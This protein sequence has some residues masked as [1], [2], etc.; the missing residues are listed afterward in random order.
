MRHPSSKE[1]VCKTSNFKHKDLQRL[2]RQAGAKAREKR[3]QGTPTARGWSRPPPAAKRRKW[4]WGLKANSQGMGRAA[5]LS[6]FHWLG[7]GGRTQ[8]GSGG[9]SWGSGGHK[10][11]RPASPHRSLAPEARSHRTHVA[12][13]LPSATN[14]PANRS[15]LRTAPAR[16]THTR[17]G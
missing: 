1:T 17:W 14:H 6:A 3:A 15:N 2:K 16:R 13:G 4:L 9:H 7:L 5:L 11:G 8:W 12:L 10:M